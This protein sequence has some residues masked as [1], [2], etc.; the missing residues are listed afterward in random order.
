ML[1][2]E[3]PSNGKNKLYPF[4]MKK[5]QDLHKKYIDALPKNVF[6]MGRNASYRYLDVGATIAQG[7]KVCQEW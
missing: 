6:S 2:I 5:D 4:P 7:F 1:G 3:I